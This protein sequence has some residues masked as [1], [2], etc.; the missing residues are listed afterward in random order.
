[1][2]VYTCDLFIHI[3]Q[4]SLTGS[5]SIIGLPQWHRRNPKDTGRS[6]VTGVNEIQQKH[7]K[8]RCL[9]ESFDNRTHTEIFVR[10]KVQHMVP[11]SAFYW[12][13]KWPVS[14]G[15]LGEIHSTITKSRAISYQSNN[16][17]WIAYRRRVY[18]SCIQKFMHRIHFRLFFLSVTSF[19]TYE[20]IS[21]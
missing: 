17:C 20:R 11:W 19:K 12:L 8:W 4:G 3:F 7:K 13:I 1:M 15:F 2:R 9:F 14:F 5:G 21:I 10:N 6:I 18:G 16:R